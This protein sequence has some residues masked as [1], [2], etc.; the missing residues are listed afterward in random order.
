MEA[1]HIQDLLPAPQDLLTVHPG[2]LPPAI[3]VH[4]AHLLHQD[5]AVRPAAAIPAVLPAAAE[6]IPEVAARIPAAVH[7]PAAVPMADPGGSLT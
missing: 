7:I 5:T 3:A 2:P 6:D 4:L 1:L